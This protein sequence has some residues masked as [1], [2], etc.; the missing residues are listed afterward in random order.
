MFER[1]TPEARRVVF[2]SRYEA[3]ELGSASIEADHLLL[4]LVR[5]AR[6]LFKR[7]APHFPSIEQVRQQIKK[8]RPPG[9]KLPTYVDLP[10]TQQAANILQNAAEEAAQLQHS[11]IGTEHLLLAVLGETGSFA[12]EI[13]RGYG[14]NLDEAR[15]TIAGTPPQT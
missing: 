15:Q 7:V 10:L 8:E 13:A 6:D 2:F 3:S 5:E 9:P 1:Y 12:A 11:H 14:L 4:G